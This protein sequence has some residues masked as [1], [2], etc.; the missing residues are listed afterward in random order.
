MEEHNNA[1]QEI[2]THTC[3]ILFPGYASLR[4][5]L[6]E[7]L[8]EEHRVVQEYFEEAAHITTLN[9]TK[10]L[11]NSS[12]SEMRALPDAYPLLFLLQASAT[13][14]LRSQNY[15]IT[16]VGGYGLGAYGALYAARAFTFPDGLYMLS[17]WAL[18]YQELL[19]HTNFKKILV[20]G[21]SH[22]ELKHII[23][24]DLNKDMSPEVAVSEKLESEQYMITGS[25]AVVEILEER[26]I[27]KFD[28]VTI[29]EE[30]LE[31][32]LY[33][34]LASTESIANFKLYLEKVEFTDAAVPCFSPHSS[35]NIK[36]AQEI[37]EFVV[38]QPFLSQDL[39]Q[40]IER[41][42]DVDTLVIPFA[43]EALLTAVK[44]RYPEK[45]IIT[46]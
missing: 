34:S 39:V 44:T 31:A 26:I 9:V 37:K 28:S 12:E 3:A 6:A 38:E 33:A 11:F 13:E 35:V 23:A 30:S 4:S 22:K 21:V 46:L 29:N 8:H 40:L 32:G 7:K 45:N 27:D 2:K 41:Y 17:K 36:T 19:E 5:G 43:D 24:H 20:S 25:R 18:A 42:A 10:L 14:Y 16:Q 15:I 1:E